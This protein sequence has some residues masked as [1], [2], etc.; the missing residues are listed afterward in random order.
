MCLIDDGDTH[1]GSKRDGT[2][3]LPAAVRDTRRW[4]NLT[5]RQVGVSADTTRGAYFL[6]G[7]LS[8]INYWSKIAE[9][10]GFENI[11]FRKT[12]NEKHGDGVEDSL[13]SRARDNKLTGNCKLNLCSYRLIGVLADISKSSVLSTNLDWRKHEDSTRV[14]ISIYF[15]EQSKVW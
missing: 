14:A 6:R 12:W 7:A 13:R 11:S 2:T 9:T 5:D 3:V 8:E 15:R 10:K 1:Q 4:Q